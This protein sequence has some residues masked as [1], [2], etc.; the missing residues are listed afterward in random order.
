[1]KPH[2]SSPFSP[3]V[4]F[5][6]AEERARL[7]RRNF[8]AILAAMGTQASISSKGMATEPARD[9]YIVP[10][11][12]PA[13]CGWLTTFSRERVYCANSYI[14]H[15]DRV[16][17]DP[18]Y[19]FVLSEINNIIAIRDFRPERFADLK[20]RVSEKRV[21]LVNGMFLEPTINLSGGEALVRMGVLGS[22][23]YEQVFGLRPRYAWTIDVCGTHEQM[24]QISSGLGFDAMVYTRKNP[25]GKSIYWSVSPDGSK[26]LTLS[27]GH[28]S[29]AGAIFSNKAELSSGQLRELDTFFDT[30]QQVTPD[31]APILVLGGGDDY[32]CAPEVKEYP[33]K[34]LDQ[35]Q[36][37]GSHN[38]IRFTTL[39]DYVD[40][41]LPRIRSGQIT[42]PTTH[43]GTAYDFDAFWIEN[44]EVKTRYRRSEQALQ[45][46]EM[47]STVASLHASFPYPSTDTYH[48]WILMCLNMDR[49]TLWGSAGGMVFVSD[50]S[51][52]VQD[53]F[54]WVGK[55]S[56]RMLDEAGRTLMKKG[57]GLA[58]FNSLNWQRRDPIALALPA[59]TTIDGI[60]CE[61][62][63]DG[64]VLCAPTLPAFSV[65]A[66]RL[67]SR[68]P[69]SPE[70]VDPSAP[71]ETDYYS[72]R[73]DLK[74]GALASLRLKPSG[75]E[76][77]AGPANVLVAER[78]TKQERD[79]GDFMPP[80]PGRTR[81][82]SSS[83][84]E[85]T[86]RVLRGPVVTTVDAEG[87]FTGSPLRR[88]V[89]FHHTYPRIDFETELNN[90]P[91]Y[92]VVV[93]EFPLAEDV[94]EIRR[95]IP[96]GFAHSN[97]SRPDSGLPGWNRGI[98]PAVRWMDFELVGGGGVAL[99][100]RGLT[101]R[102]I[103]GNIPIV[104]LLNAEDEY[105]K[106]PNEWTT[107]KGRHVLPY[108]L[109]PHAAAWPQAAIPRLAWEYNQPAIS[110]ANAVPA[111]FASYLETSENI[112]V[113]AVRREKGFIE[114]RFAECLGVAGTANV[115]LNLP[116]GPVHRT[117]LAGKPLSALSG[118]RTYT[119]AVE[120]QQIVTLH[121][122]TAD[123]LP[124]PDPVSSW[125]ELVPEHK[126]AALH[127]YDPNVK[128]HP[129]FG[130]GSIEF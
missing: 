89:R 17:S 15:L 98:V 91:N 31:G 8:I 108:A 69:A 44:P 73:I 101:G 125:D 48:A 68:P 63:P 11:F 46:A 20:K 107:G 13:S 3:S 117:D 10:N 25:T 53:R 92:T 55:T 2:N 49:N 104:Y 21:E 113:E 123:T 81:F 102:E 99:F 72:A 39:S 76:L 84:D 54:D 93:A 36:T 77:L 103:N 130:S 75:R 115:T 1:L 122:E 96:Y 71:I 47:L 40:A 38:R 78:P 74:T 50:T 80:R 100:D 94:T 58:V 60:A 45:A 110:L 67:S 116:H 61:K 105:H 23:W 111:P 16:D 27:P 37:L 30:K 32:S 129:P 87:T 114:L 6:P 12:H 126:R 127:A 57:D 118:T 51:W 79:P 59:G 41:I 9:I 95:G 28:Y 83:D 62:L 106:F 85:S 65:G 42:I 33:S 97:W 112:V 7:S 66:L 5:T 88:R 14:T 26:I 19:A 24:A 121:F 109:C 70:P 18:H 86:V 29:E 82:A 34:L 119:L 90:V 128:G 52:D 43:A 64:S 35:W 124:V 56:V 22:R 120:P 4:S